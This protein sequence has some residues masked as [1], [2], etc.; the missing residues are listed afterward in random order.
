MQSLSKH[1]SMTGTIFIDAPSFYITVNVIE[2]QKDC[3]N[4]YK[5]SYYIEV[6]CMSFEYL[7]ICLVCILH[8]PQ[9][10]NILILSTEKIK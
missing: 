3:V 7:Y 2:I 10:A 9:Y 6:S 5:F 4:L 8:Q 1:N